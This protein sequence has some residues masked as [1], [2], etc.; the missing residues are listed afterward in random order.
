MRL[1]ADGRFHLCLLNDD[2]LDVR[3]TIRAGGD[4]AAVGEILVRAVRHK[5]T[6]HRLDLGRTTADRQM[7]QI[8]G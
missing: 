2:E 6:G 7:F 4:V 8:G 1:T 3:A 5:P